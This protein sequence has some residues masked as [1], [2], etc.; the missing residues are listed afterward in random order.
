M[1]DA[2]FKLAK[3]YHLEGRA[4]DAQRLLNRVVADHA[5]SS[6]ARLAAEYRQQNF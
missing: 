4:G 6:A 2:M 3:V 5:G 1:P